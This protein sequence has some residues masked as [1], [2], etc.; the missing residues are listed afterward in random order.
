MTPIDPI[1]RAKMTLSIEVNGIHLPVPAVP[2]S[3]QRFCRPLAFYN[4]GH[5]Q[6][7]SF[8]GSCLLVRHNGHNLLVCSRHQLTNAARQPDEI[9]IVLDGKD[10][11]RMGMNPSEV[12]QAVSD[13]SSDPALADLADIMLAEYSSNQPDRDL[14]PHFLPLNLATTPDLRSVPSASA[15]AIFTIGYPTSDTSYDTRFDEEWTVIGVDIVSH[16]WKLYLRQA[17]PTP[18][19]G[20]GLIPLVPARENVLVL[21]D[22]DGISGA[23]VFFIHGI[24]AHKPGLGFAGII[25][26]ANKQGRAN[27]L[28][29]AHTRQMLRQHFDGS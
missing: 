14:A 11:P 23:P 8:S 25:I 22:Q 6:E 29:A 24:K 1:T 3:L 21:E 19:D 4:K 13:P 9:V 15:D 12:S 26:R 10:G 20:P 16:W 18:W 27:M 7:L 2:G 5:D 17:A 28:E